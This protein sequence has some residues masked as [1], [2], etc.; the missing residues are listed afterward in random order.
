M[1]LFPGLLKGHHQTELP[2]LPL[3]LVF[4][5]YKCSRDPVECKLLS[6]RLFI[7]SALSEKHKTK[8]LKGV[9]LC[10][11]RLYHGCYHAQAHL[12]T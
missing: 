11:H 6:A 4:L 7:S 1:I 12:H 8:Y 5:F 9:R 3:D 10:A 2:E